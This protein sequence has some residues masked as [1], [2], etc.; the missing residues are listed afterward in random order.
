MSRVFKDEKAPY[1]SEEGESVGAKAGRR[2]ALDTEVRPG[3][4]RGQGWWWVALSYTEQP[5]CAG[6]CPSSVS[7]GPHV[8]AGCFGLKKAQVKGAQTENDLA[9]RTSTEAGQISSQ[10]I[11]AFKGVISMVFRC[12]CSAIHRLSF[13]LRVLLMVTQQLP[14]YTRLLDC[15]QWEKPASW[16]SHQR[17]RK[18]LITIPWK[19]SFLFHWPNLS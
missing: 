9:Q 4:A 13:I 1:V 11:Q 14:K 16:G 6:N 17:A 3:G 15:D 8:S 10:M 5:L 7:L 2:S 12:L 19:T 18:L